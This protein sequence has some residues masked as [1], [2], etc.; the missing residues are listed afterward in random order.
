MFDTLSDKLEGVFRKIR[1]TGR[2]TEANVEEAL[3]DVRM[4]LLEADVNFQVAKDFVERVKAQAMGQDVLR[5]LSP[6][7]QLVKIVHQ[8]L[9]ATM[10]G[11]A[12]KLD[13]AGDPPAVL[14]LVGLQGSGK[15][16]T[17]GKLA[18]MLLGLA[19]VI[20]YNLFVAQYFEKPIEQIEEGLL[21]IVNGN[22]QHRINVEHAELGG[23]V[24]RINQLVASLTGEGDEGGED[25]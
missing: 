9:T 24:Y 13:L 7:Q 15:T 12:G 3:R 5:A 25:S 22:T 1:G 11:A 6:D 19:M 2:I 8:Q 16:T 18:T 23:I 10:G 17:A 14:M 21:T 20:G 4:A